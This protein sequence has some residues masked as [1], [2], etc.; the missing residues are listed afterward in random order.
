MSKHCPACDQLILEDETV[1]WHCGQPLGTNTTTSTAPATAS[2]ISPSP[3]LRRAVTSPLAIYA[4]LSTL[5]IAAACLLTVL[6]GA[7]PRASAASSSPPDGWLAVVD[8]QRTISLFLPEQWQLWDATNEDERAEVNAI[9]ERASIYR[10]ATAPLGMLATDVEPVLFATGAEAT[11]YQEP[12]PFLLVAQSQTLNRLDRP[13]AIALA[14]AGGVPV[15]SA[16]TVD[17]FEKR[18]VALLVAPAGEG[19]DTWRCQQQFTTGREKAVIVALCYRPGTIDV[20]A[21]ATIEESIQRI[22]R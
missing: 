21:L 18:Y 11:D 19:D 14:R 3:D 17:D 13:E 9:F 2:E 5:V 4:A 8:R 22:A 6:L 15:L 20:D 10:E 12:G 7:Q 1:C 16:T